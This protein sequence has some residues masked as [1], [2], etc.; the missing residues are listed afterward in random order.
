MTAGQNPGHNLFKQQ[1][2]PHDGF[3]DFSDDSS[4]HVGDIF[5]RGGLVELF[6]HNEPPV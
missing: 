4:A 1:C 2:F 5:Q 3:L 6:G